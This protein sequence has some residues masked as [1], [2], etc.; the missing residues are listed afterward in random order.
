[1]EQADQEQPEPCPGQEPHQAGG[2]LGSES[3]QPQTSSRYQT[4]SCCEDT[5]VGKEAAVIVGAR[6][7][8]VQWVCQVSYFPAVADPVSVGIRVGGVSAPLCFYVVGEAVTIGIS[9]AQG[10]FRLVFSRSR[11]RR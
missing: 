5:R 11:C 3:G 4:R 2:D 10:E 6:I 1:M 8:R 7:I 9:F